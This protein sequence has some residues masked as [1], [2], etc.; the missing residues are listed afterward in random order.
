MG[1]TVTLASNKRVNNCGR[2]KQNLRP[3]KYNYYKGV[4]ALPSKVTALKEIQRM[5]I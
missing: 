5:Y 4:P 1:A 3:V 2:K